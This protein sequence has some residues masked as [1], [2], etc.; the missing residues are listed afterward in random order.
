ME[1]APQAR[2]GSSAILPPPPSPGS[3]G[4]AAT[5]PAPS[6]R[7]EL[8][9]MIERQRTTDGA[10]GQRSRGLTTDLTM[11]LRNTM[12]DTSRAVDHT[13]RSIRDDSERS[14]RKSQRHLMA[15][16]ASCPQLM[17]DCRLSGWLEKRGH[18]RKNWK[19]RYFV[20]W[21]AEGTWSSERFLNYYDGPNSGVDSLHG[22]IPVRNCVIG[23]V[24][25]GEENP[26]GDPCFV[27][28]VVAPGHTKHSYTLSA[29]TLQEIDVWKAALT[30]RAAALEKVERKKTL[31]SNSVMTL[32]AS[33]GMTVSSAMW[34]VEVQ[35]PFEPLYRSIT[36]STGRLASQHAAT[37][38]AKSIDEGGSG[39]GFA[40][41][42][43]GVSME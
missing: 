9:S 7:T 19:R 11:S 28:N 34:T 33:P 35:N 8:E 18:R 17:R 5:E 4:R 40:D 39:E 12:E 3:F 41:C 2:L 13:L 43:V 29:S 14:K 1:P 23:R 16:A 42:F 22:S 30:S 20:L 15:Q 38:S 25:S 27:L 31:A 37:W 24:L 32:Q 6:P 26:N 10:A 21:P 36:T